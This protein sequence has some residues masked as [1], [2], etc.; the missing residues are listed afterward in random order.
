[1]PTELMP[2]PADMDSVI[3][4]SFEAHGRRGWL[5]TEI[6]RWLWDG[7]TRDASRAAELIDRN[8]SEFERYGELSRSVREKLSPC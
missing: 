5:H 3:A 8:R 1:M 7:V 4:T 6:D 2:I